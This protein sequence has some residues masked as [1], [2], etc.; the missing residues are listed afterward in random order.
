[1]QYLVDSRAGRYGIFRASDPTFEAEVGPWILVVIEA[2]G[3]GARRMFSAVFTFPI[4]GLSYGF[5]R[6][7]DAS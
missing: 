3:A 7:Y 4:D 6:L 1:M 5:D 2:F